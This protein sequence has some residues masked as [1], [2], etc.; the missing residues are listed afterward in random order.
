MRGENIW[1]STDLG[2]IKLCGFVDRGNLKMAIGFGRI[3]SRRYVILI[4][5]AENF[6]C[7]LEYLIRHFSGFLGREG[8]RHTQTDLE[9]G[10]TREV[11]QA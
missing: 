8:A 5:S 4:G 2:E 7:L 6:S 1:P 10:N 9:A 11:R 3:R